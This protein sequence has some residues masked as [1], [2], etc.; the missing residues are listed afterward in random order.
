ML[1]GR[2]VVVVLP[3]FNAA[4]TLEQTVR[5]IDRDVADEVLLVDDASTDDTSL[6]AHRLGLRSITHRDNRGYGGNQKTCYA[7]ALA[8]GADVV[9]MV[10]PDYQYSP[11]LV[12]AM[13]GMVTSGHYELVLGSRVLAQHPVAKGMPRYKYIANRALTAVDNVVLRQ[14]LSEYH[15]GLRAFSAELLRSLPLER[16][17]DDF[18]FD[19]QLIVQAVASGARIGEVSCPTRYA[20]ESSSISFRRS[21]RY[22]AGVLATA[23]SYLLDRT[24]LHTAPFLALDER[25]WARP[26]AAPP[27]STAGPLEGH[28][29]SGCRHAG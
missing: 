10:H 21:V 8:A 29:A 19:N 15:T 20:A 16:N 23:A 22:G 26:A 17:S 12:T 25:P 24:G 3:A 18:V 5:E 28:P 13:A 1:D 14:R 2:R 6:V 27:P 7:A 4:L 9:V 11:R